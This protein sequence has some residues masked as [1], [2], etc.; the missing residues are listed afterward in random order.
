MKKILPPVLLFALVVIGHLIVSNRGILSG[1]FPPEG[2]GPRGY[3][4]LYLRTGNVLFGIS[5][6]LGAAFI[7]YVLRKYIETPDKMKVLRGLVVATVLFMA[8]YFGLGLDG[9]YLFDFYVNRVSWIYSTM[10]KPL[11]LLV[12]VISVGAGVI[13]I[14]RQTRDKG[15]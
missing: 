1:G 10:M 13:V 15:S 8:L 4:A 12:T 2:V 5:Y 9:V 11:L 6:G 7:L 14:R 3:L